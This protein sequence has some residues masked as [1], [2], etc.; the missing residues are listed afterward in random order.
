MLSLTISSSEL[1]DI[2]CKNKTVVDDSYAKVL[3]Y[4]Y[5]YRKNEKF[6]RNKIHT[7]SVD[8]IYNLIKQYYNID[9]QNH[10]QQNS[11]INRHVLN[12]R[13]EFLLDVFSLEVLNP[14]KIVIN[15]IESN[16][17][18]EIYEQHYYNNDIITNG[19]I[20]NEFIKYIV[21]IL[22][23]LIDLNNN[24]NFENTSNNVDIIWIVMNKDKSLYSK[25]DIISKCIE[26]TS[27][28]KDIYDKE[29]FAIDIDIIVSYLINNNIIKEY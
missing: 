19:H 26:Y 29:N 23:M 28:N 22:K 8:I 4:L 15:E 17:S 11:R 2:V 13:L 6:S 21:I 1:K 3:S 10:Q 14:R 16:E 27:L 18:Y 12:K 7:T 24:G 9:L 25:D 20:V 5:K